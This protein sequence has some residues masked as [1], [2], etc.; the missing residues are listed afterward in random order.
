M[1]YATDTE[2]NG[3]GGELISLALV[4][5]HGEHE[6]LYIV[7]DFD[8][9]AIHPWVAEHVIPHLGDQP[10]VSRETAARMVAAYLNRSAKPVVV[11]DWPEDLSQLLMLSVI[12]P[13]K[14][15]RMPDV[16]YQY[17]RLEGFDA[18]VDSKTPHNALEDAIALRDHLI[19]LKTD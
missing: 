16:T 11:A 17:V 15:V 13:G 8:E 10:R 19:A 6:P 12:G 7:L 5:L 2:F 18:A 14:M 1:I 3:F 9:T 4:P